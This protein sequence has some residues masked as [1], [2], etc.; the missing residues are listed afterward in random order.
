[1]ISRHW[2]PPREISW[3]WKSS[4]NLSESKR[5]PGS[6]NNTGE[7]DRGQAGERGAQVSYDSTNLRPIVQA[8]ERKR[9]LKCIT[10]SRCVGGPEDVVEL[11]LLG[12]RGHGTR[13]VAPESKAE[14]S[15]M[16]VVDVPMENERVD[17]FERLHLLPCIGESSRLKRLAVGAI[18][19]VKSLLAENDPAGLPSEPE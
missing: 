16:R 9:E 8:D 4:G 7:Y 13:L 2:G 11:L 15:L 19:R 5:R 1:M 14:A 6:W 3:S 12:R 10:P 17:A 18:R